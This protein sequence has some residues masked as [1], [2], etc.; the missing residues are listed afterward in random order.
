MAVVLFDHACIGMPQVLSDYEQGYA[1]HSG[2]ACPSVTKRM[3][4]DRRGNF[5]ASARLGYRPHLVTL[6]PHRAVGLSEHWLAS[7]SVKANL[8]EEGC[9][10]ICQHDVAR[11]AGLTD[12]DRDGAIVSVEVIHSQPSEFT[13]S[14]TRFQRGT[15]EISKGGVAGL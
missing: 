2:E 6:V 4:V 11:F 10:V 1:I 12:A 13:I 9:P 14:G 5:G 8:F 3:K 15:N 7:Y